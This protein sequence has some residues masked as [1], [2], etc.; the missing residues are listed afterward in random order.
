MFKRHIIDTYYRFYDIAFVRK[1]LQIFVCENNMNRVLRNSSKIIKRKK[2][3]M[4]E[5]FIK[6]F[7]RT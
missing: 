1:Q 3:P 2:M 4:S 6:I 5:K 7:S